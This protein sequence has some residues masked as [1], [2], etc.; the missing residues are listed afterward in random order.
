M[1]IQPK[2]L[3]I[4]LIRMIAAKN[5]H[6][7]RIMVSNTFLRRKGLPLSVTSWAMRSKPMARETRM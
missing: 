2:V 3:A 5:G 1:D 6:M 4:E 7:K